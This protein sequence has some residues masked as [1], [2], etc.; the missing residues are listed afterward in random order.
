MMP[1]D[2]IYLVA[3]LPHTYTLDKGYIMVK[4]N[5]C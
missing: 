3:P 2:Y 4:S 5:I 1:I